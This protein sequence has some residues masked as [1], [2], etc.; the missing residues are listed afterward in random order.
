MHVRLLLL[1]FTLL[2]VVVSNAQKPEIDSI[3]MNYEQAFNRALDE[4]EKF[5]V[6]HGHFI[7]TPN[8][9]LHY[10]TWGDSNNTPFI[11]IHGTY[12]NS[13]EIIDVVD[14]IVASG[15][16]VTAIDVYGHG[17]TEIPNHEVSIYHVADDINCL[18][19]KLNLE[20]A[21]IGGT[22]RGGSIATAFYDAYPNKVLGIINSDGGSVNWLRPRQKMTDAEL[23][24][25][26]EKL[27]R[28]TETRLFDSKFEIF[29]YYYNPEDSTSQYWWFALIEENESNK[30]GLNLALKALVTETTIESGVNKILR[31]TTCS[32]LDASTSMMLP[33]VVYRN[34]SVPVLI[35]DPQKDD[36]DGLFAFTE[37]NKKLAAQHPELITHILYKN[38][39]H[40]VIF[41]QPERFTY[42][43]LGFLDQIKK[44]ITKP[45]LH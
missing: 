33:E 1:L 17:L 36:K 41:E 39:G 43:V 30:W 38:S 35:L 21:V 32:L 37:Y 27:Y 42:D 23:R 5:E 6:E 34:L 14:S 45:K 19:N 29:K 7:E 28:K 9:K 13:T 3:N 18:M 40:G 4:Y 22:S 31:P 25:A 26:Y 15:F 10:S 12:Q 2:N 16:Y 44:D 20:K 8:V 24:S 11:W